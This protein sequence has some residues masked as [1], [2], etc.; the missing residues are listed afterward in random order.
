MVVVGG[1]IPLA[2]TSHQSR[3]RTR[4]RLFFFTIRCKKKLSA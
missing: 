2:P 3:K 1:S 4:L